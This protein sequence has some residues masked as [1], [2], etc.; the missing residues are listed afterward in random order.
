MARS[1]FSSTTMTSLPV[2]FAEFAHGVLTVFDKHEVEARLNIAGDFKTAQIAIS[3][4]AGNA[5][6]LA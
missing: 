5:L 2:T 3:N 6:T 1:T 4:E